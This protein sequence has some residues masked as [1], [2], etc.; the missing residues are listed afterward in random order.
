MVKKCLMGHIGPPGPP[1]PQ[2]LQGPEGSRGFSSAHGYIYNVTAQVVAPTENIPFSNNGII[3]GAISHNIGSEEIIIEEVGDYAVLFQVTGATSNQFSIFLDGKPIQNTLYGTD[4]DNQQNTSQS[5]ITIAEVPAV[6]TVKYYDNISILPVTLQSPAGGS[7]TN[8]TASLFI[9]KLGAQTT[10]TVTTEAEL[11]AAM[12]NDA[13]STVRVAPGFYDLS[14]SPSISRSTAVRLESVTPGATIELNSD[15]EYTFI[16]TSE[17]VTVH[18]N[19]IRNINSG[20]NY[21]SIPAAIIAAS[22]GDTIE[23]SPGRYTL[24]SALIINRP[25]TL[26]GISA[27]LTEIEFVLAPIPATGFLSISADQVII[28]NLHWIGPTAPSGDSSLFNIPTNGFPG[29]MYKNI[30]MRYNIFEGGRRTAFIKAEDLSLIGN[31]ILHNGDRDVFVLERVAGS[32]LIYGNRLIGGPASRRAFSIE[33]GNS[34]DFAAGTITI[35]NNFSTRFSQYVLFNTVPSNL[36]LFIGENYLDHM[37][38]SGSSIIFLPFGDF[39]LIN[40]ILIDDNIVINP[41]PE[42]LAVYVDF[43]SG[44]TFVPANDQI[45]VY[46]NKFSFQL[47]WGKAT[48]TV[49]TLFPVGYSS[50]APITMSLNVFDLQNNVNF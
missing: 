12:L 27:R 9:Q 4:D 8:V 24:T 6:M 35:S 38:R 23:L 29:V 32:T 28:E 10:V 18:S 7:Q 46:N 49:D 5:I 22:D 40:T 21:P 43:S 50:G 3:S 34:F 41:N 44:G 14:V 39:S 26:R 31:T 17:D 11:L 36:D 20:I 19:R 13:V 33:T 37:D 16:T 42:R 2:G 1:G 15:Q 30:A 48:D 47:P 25:L 45:Q